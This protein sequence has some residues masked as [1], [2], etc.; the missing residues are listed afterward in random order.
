M[1]CGRPE[2][3]VLGLVRAAADELGAAIHDHLW[4]IDTPTVDHV[5]VIFLPKGEIGRGIR[6]GPA[7]PVPVV[8]MF[9]ESN[10]FDAVEGL[11]VAEQGEVGIGRGAARAAFGGEE[12]DDD[13]LPENSGVRG[14]G[15]TAGGPM[16]Q[17][18]QASNGGGEEESEES[19][20]HGN[21]LKALDWGTERKLQEKS[22]KNGAGKADYLMR[23]RVRDGEQI[24]TT[25]TE[26]SRG[27]P[28][29]LGIK[30]HDANAE[31]PRNT[32]RSAGPRADRREDRLAQGGLLELPGSA[33]ARRCQDQ[34]IETQLKRGRAMPRSG[35]VA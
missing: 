30:S 20:G 27:S 11:S 2:D 29:V 31:W 35:S 14:G 34:R 16:P 25:R 28:V 24:L 1:S 23:R 26:A 12:F 19:F 10:H 7:L 32:C 9:F 18:G 3:L 22:Q 4:G 8:H 21:S 6:V 15:R 13:G 5:G 33:L 17:G